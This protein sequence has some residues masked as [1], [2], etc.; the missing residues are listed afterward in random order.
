MRRFSFFLIFLLLLVVFSL[1]FILQNNTAIVQIKFFSWSIENIPLGVLVLIS[2]ISGIV[3][4]WLLSLIFYIASEKKYRRTVTDIAKKLKKIEEEKKYLENELERY[5][6][7]LEEK[8]KKYVESTEK[9]LTGEQ[10]NAEGYENAFDDKKS[11][12]IENYNNQNSG[13]DKE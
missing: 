5:R 12:E 2:L 7:E 13:K 10:T 4:I 11:S 3:I 8:S 1:I 6:I 9:E